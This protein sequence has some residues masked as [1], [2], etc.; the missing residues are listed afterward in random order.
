MFG[1]LLQYATA[2]P[3]NLN[4]NVEVSEVIPP[5]LWANRRNFGNHFDAFGNGSVF[6]VFLPLILEPYKGFLANLVFHIHKLVRL[7]AH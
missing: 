2:S 3:R 6:Y 5:I 4:R 7:V 1:C